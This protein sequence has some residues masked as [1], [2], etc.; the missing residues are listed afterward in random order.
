MRSVSLSEAFFVILSLPRRNRQGCALALLNTIE[1]GV[2]PD[3]TA[4]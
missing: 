4:K 2:Y 3:W 1:R